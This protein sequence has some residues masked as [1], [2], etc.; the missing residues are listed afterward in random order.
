MLLTSA[1]GHGTVVRLR[2]PRTAAAAPAL[3]APGVPTRR[4][5]VV[6]DEP[7]VR[8]VLARLLTRERC[9]VVEV[10]DAA[11][12]LAL[13]DATAFDLLVTDVVLGAGL[14]GVA[15]GRE[16]RRR[17]PGLPVIYV[18]GYPRDALALAALAAGEWFLP[19]P[20]AIADLRATLR[21]ALAAIIASA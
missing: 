4:V 18:S 15:L 6:D 13:L 2:F 12:A 14:D 9:H 5:L 1:D 17:R 11:Q 16:A 3:A 8:R 10:A 19:K 7:E 20:V 21:E